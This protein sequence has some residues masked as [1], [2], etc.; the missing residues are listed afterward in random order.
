[1]EF[2]DNKSF[3]YRSLTCY[4][5]VQSILSRMNVSYTSSFGAMLSTQEELEH[6][7]VEI[8]GSYKSKS[9]KND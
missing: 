9:E 4:V 7:M 8:P 1:M 6:L 3:K 2:I 5:E